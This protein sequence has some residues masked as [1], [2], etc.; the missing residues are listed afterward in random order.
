[1]HP[2]LI[3]YALVLALGFI[4]GATVNGWRLGGRVESIKADHAAQITDIVSV[5]SAAASDAL[6]R[7]R[8]AQA[9]LSVIDHQYTQELTDARA[10]SDRLRSAVADNQRQLRVQA[11]CPDPGRGEVRSATATTG[12]DDA[13]GPGLTRA[14]ERNYFTLRDRIATVTAQV[15]GLQAY[16]NTACV[17]ER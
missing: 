7:Q 9:A 14:A 2:A 8:K 15:E 11:T 16:I 17:V 6:E 13:A 12:M 1:M 5:A 4:V 3:K 10:E